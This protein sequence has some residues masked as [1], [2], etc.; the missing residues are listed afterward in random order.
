MNKV[1]VSFSYWERKAQNSV[2]HTV[3]NRF[4]GQTAGCRVLTPWYEEETSAPEYSQWCYK[5][6][7]IQNV[8]HGPA[9]LLSS[10]SIV[11]PCQSR[12]CQIGCPCF[13]CRGY[14][15]K[16]LSAE[17]RFQDHKFYHHATHANCEFCCQ[18]LEALPFYTF[19]LHIRKGMY[20]ED[21]YEVKIKTY[22][23]GHNFS[24]KEKTK[25]ST[26][27]PL[28][29]EDC[30]KRFKT[31]SNRDRHF[32]NVHF[33]QKIYKCETCKKEFGRI[34]NLR[35][36]KKIHQDKDDFIYHSDSEDASDEENNTKIKECNESSS[37]DDTSDD[38]EDASDVQES[39]ETEDDEVNGNSTAVDNSNNIESMHLTE[40]YEEPAE[41]E[42][43]NSVDHD[44]DIDDQTERRKDQ[45][46]SSNNH[47]CEVCGKEFS[48]KYNL[49]VHKR[50]GKIPCDICDQVF[51]SKGALVLHKKLKH[52]QRKFKCEFCT[53]EFDSKYHLNR[54]L[55]TR[56][57][58]GCE[59]CSALLCN[60]VDLTRHVYIEHKCKVCEICN[61]KFEYIHKHMR[62]DHGNYVE[63]QFKTMK[64]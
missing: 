4:D 9:S 31:T 22:E 6:S 62:E 47:T 19:D 13:G 51:C 46:V 26:K 36:H 38:D 32:R 60:S 28:K 17:T 52:N 53:R 55:D 5:P 21:I 7:Q 37:S 33:K 2:S 56:S 43:D 45:V 1:Q 49:E 42:D 34:D 35:R 41:D 61:Q 15:V 48:A 3:T 30:G 39:G 29:C 20:A 10:R 59:Y 14:L 24:L 27:C 8:L 23:F 44:A 57:P 64:N 40:S 50:K 12:L 11:Y 16:K 54:H 18:L 58:S 25:S 63:K